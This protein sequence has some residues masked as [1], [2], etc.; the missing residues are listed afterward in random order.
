M[1]VRGA[2]ITFTVVAALG[3]AALLGAAAADQRSSAFSLD[4][5]PD[6]PI[7]TLSP[8]DQVCQGP[9]AATA[10]FGS[11]TAWVSP[12]GN[13]GASLRMLVRSV[14]GATLATG[15]SP[16]GYHQLATARTFRLDAT[17]AAGRRISVCLRSAGPEQ[18]AVLGAGARDATQLAN[19]GRL[20]PTGR[21]PAAAIALVFTRRHPRSLLSLFPT[22]FRRAAV[23][24]PPWVGPWTYWVLVAGVLAAFVLGGLAVTRAVRS[25]TRSD[26][27]S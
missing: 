7:A 23:F 17:V 21:S 25:D 10:S 6:E 8:G 24:R 16:A 11:V 15:Q 5:S 3:L 14:S 20:R 2:L 18:V 13:V 26:S 27:P 1:S 19:V 4:V 9:F 12:F 22:I